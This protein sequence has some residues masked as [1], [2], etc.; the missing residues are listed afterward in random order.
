MR[1]PRP[2]ARRGFSL[3]E[4]IIA[5]V[6]FFVMLLVFQVL[7]QLST[8]GGGRDLRRTQALMMAAEVLEQTVEVH[9]R[10]GDLPVGTRAVSSK[11]PRSRVLFPSPGGQIQVAPDVPEFARELRVTELRAG[12]ED[13]LIRP[14][15]AYQVTVE[16]SYPGPVGEQRRV[17]LTTVRA[18]KVWVKAR[19]EV[20]PW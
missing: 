8:R 2:A 3:I 10:V 20:R 14:D 15:R 17:T 12:A 6:V 5:A 7:F 1:S 18:R 13:G 11:D 16:V 19:G 4:V 9:A